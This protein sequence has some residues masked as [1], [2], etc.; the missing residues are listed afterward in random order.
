MQRK[1]LFV[2]L[3]LAILS[4]GAWFLVVLKIPPAQNIYPLFFAFL[5]FALFS[6]L[7]LILKKSR[8]LIF[9]LVI[10]IFLILRLLKMAHPLNLLLLLA[11]LL[12]SEL[13]LR[14]L[15]PK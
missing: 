3:F 10:V 1:K 11:L 14:Q 4:W 9:S 15:P 5:L 2:P 7:S 6:T 13:Y 12:V 8:A